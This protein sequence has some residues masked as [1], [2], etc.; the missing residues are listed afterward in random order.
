MK[1]TV[2]ITVVALTACASTAELANSQPVRTY[3]STNSRAEIAKCLLDRMGGSGMRPERA[4]SSGV[5]RLRFT[6][7]NQWSNPGLYLFT[8]RDKNAGSLVE[9]RIPHGFEKLGL[10]T[11]ETCF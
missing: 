9:A 11:A 2:V 7:L 5:T 8:V 10:P 3:Y 1:F 6:S 4:D